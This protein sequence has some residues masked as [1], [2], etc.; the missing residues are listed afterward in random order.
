VV[1]I[2]DVNIVFVGTS[3]GNEEAA[4]AMICEDFEILDECDADD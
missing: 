3:D 2:T 1:N 4:A